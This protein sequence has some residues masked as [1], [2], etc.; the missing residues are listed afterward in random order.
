MWPWLSLLLVI[1]LFVQGKAHGAGES[2]PLLLVGGWGT[3]P[4]PPASARHPRP[5]TP[6]TLQPPASQLR[7]ARV[8]PAARCLSLCVPP[9][10]GGSGPRALPAL[11]RHAACWAAP[12][13]LPQHSV[14]ERATCWAAVLALCQQFWNLLLRAGCMNSQGAGTD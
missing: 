3:A 8:V 10:V 13:V 14:V 9:M 1:A 12:P 7:M 4:L 5:H 11:L 2:L 6:R